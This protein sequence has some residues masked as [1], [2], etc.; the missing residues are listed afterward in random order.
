MFKDNC[1]DH[2]M[3]TLK[4]LESHP[5]AAFSQSEVLL[6]LPKRDAGTSLITIGQ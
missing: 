4:P 6:P 5:N 2:E 3:L 1:E